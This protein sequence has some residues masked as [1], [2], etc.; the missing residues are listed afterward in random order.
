M[1]HGAR[2]LA[3]PTYHIRPM[4]ETAFFHDGK[5]RATRTIGF[6]GIEQRWISRS[7]IPRR[8]STTGEGVPYDHTFN[9]GVPP[10]QKSHDCR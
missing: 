2:S 10:L 9:R 3:V 4:G 1:L 6:W 7:A 8:S 5:Q